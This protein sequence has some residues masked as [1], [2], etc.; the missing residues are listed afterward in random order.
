MA[1]F[2]T[3]L[4]ARLWGDPDVAA[5]VVGGGKK[6]IYWGIAP[7]EAPLP[8]IVLTT[9]SDLRREHLKGRDGARQTRVQC[10][11]F[12]LTYGASRQL[13]EKVIEAVEDPDTVGGVRF[14]HTSADGPRDL[15]ED[16]AG[17]GYIHRA[18]VEMLVEHRLT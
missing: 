5:V 17:V 6:R 18:S 7:Q 9:I 12:A 4:F 2:A 16:V 1:D 13:A 14:G 10:D 15:G 11:C 8:Y 3:A